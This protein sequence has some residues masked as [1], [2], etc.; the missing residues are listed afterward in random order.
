M[1]ILFRYIKGI[2]LL[3]GLLTVSSIDE[4]EPIGI[5]EIFKYI[6]DQYEDNFYKYIR[7]RIGAVGK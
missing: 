5:N 7:E 2:S 3:I 6:W 1:Q 4:W